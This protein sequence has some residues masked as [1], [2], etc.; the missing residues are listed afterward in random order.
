MVVIVC[1]VICYVVYRMVT[2]VYMDRP[3]CLIYRDGYGAC[4]CLDLSSLNRPSS[5]ICRMLHPTKRHAQSTALWNS[6]QCK[7]W[8]ESP[9]S[10][11]KRRADPFSVLYSYSYSVDSSFH[12]H[13]PPQIQ[14]E[15]YRNHPISIYFAPA[16]TY[17]LASFDL[18]R[19]DSRMFGLILI[20][21]C[22]KD[23]HC[24]CCQSQCYGQ[25]FGFADEESFQLM[26]VYWLIPKSETVL[27]FLKLRRVWVLLW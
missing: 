12:F 5:G 20:F 11:W 6:Y 25:S 16:S 18:I 17:P 13:N 3:S 24:S 23:E 19:N 14:L 1:Q 8:A 4:N 26:D 15:S 7:C 21:S 10:F 9:K 22:T 27:V 2:W